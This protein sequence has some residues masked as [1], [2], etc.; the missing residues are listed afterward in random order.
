HRHVEARKR[1]EQRYDYRPEPNGGR[2]VGVRS[3][4]CHRLIDTCASRVAEAPSDGRSQTELRKARGSKRSGMLLASGS[5]LAWPK[6]ISAPTLVPSSNV[7]LWQSW[8]SLHNAH[9]RCHSFFS[10]AGPF[11]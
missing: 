6:S 10:T 5:L 2:G 9:T 11:S 4:P 3:V 8:T 7:S 1:S